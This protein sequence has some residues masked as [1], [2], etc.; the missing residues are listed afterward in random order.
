M[1]NFKT[2]YAFFTKIIFSVCAAEASTTKITFDSWVV[3]WLL[4]KY[5]NLFNH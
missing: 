3:L 5:L 2:H 1:K 4:V